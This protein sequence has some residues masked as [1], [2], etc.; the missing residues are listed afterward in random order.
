MI[1]ISMQIGDAMNLRHLHTFSVIAD[2]GGFTRAQARLHLTQPALTRQIHALEEELGVPLFDRIGRGIKLTSE[3]EELLRSSR[4]VLA[5]AD[6][7]SERARSLKAGK[8]GILRIGATAH[9]LE[10]LLAAFLAAHRRRHPGVEVHLIEE[11]GARM[12]ERLA[13]G[14][15]HLACMSAGDPRF[16]S[17]LLAPMHL[18]AVLPKRHRLA[19]HRTLEIGELAD[20]PL[21]VLEER[22]A[23]REWFDDACRA[24]RIRPRVLLESAVPQTLLALAAQAHG[25]AILPSNVALPAGGVV[26]LPLL[27]RGASIGKWQVVAWD[28]QRFLAPYARDFVDELAASVERVFP[29]HGVI[30]EAPPLPKPTRGVR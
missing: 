4:R 20:E 30:R 12:P 24:A 8:T 13:R 7:L 10:N 26:A 6:S 5:E 25:I 15:M 17:R 27:R 11:G 3:G 28:P 14:D 1:A 2:L 22:F 19:R 21:L 23:S 9:V 16:E 18:L 29:G